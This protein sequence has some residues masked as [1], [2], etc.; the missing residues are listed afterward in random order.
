VGPWSEVGGAAREAAARGQVGGAPGDAGAGRVAER[1][2]AG[3]GAVGAVLYS[4][5]TRR[6]VEQS[7]SS[8]GS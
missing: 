3:L 6:G 7:G 5:F 2:A 1:L 8:S 4:P